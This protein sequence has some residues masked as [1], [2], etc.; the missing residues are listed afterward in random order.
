MLGHVRD[1]ARSGQCTVL[2]IT[3]KFREVMAYADNVTVLRRG[4]A[5]HHC[6]VSATQ[7]AT[8]A[9]AMMGTETAASTAQS[10]TRPA[11]ALP[12]VVRRTMPLPAPG[13]APALQVQHLH[14]M[15]DR[16]TLAVHDLSLSVAAGEILGVA[17]VCRATASASWSKPWSA[18]VP[19][20]QV[21]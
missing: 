18:S 19:G 6:T 15:G 5:V 21:P 1:F 2:I 12:A 14:A 9:A 17:G 11:E 16:G 10:G 20:C 7:P 8:L 4:Q 13:A 3:H